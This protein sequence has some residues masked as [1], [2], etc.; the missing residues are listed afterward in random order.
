MSKHPETAFELAE[1]TV[2][3]IH[4]TLRTG[5]RISG[6]SRTAIYNAIGKGELD[7]WRKGDRVMLSN[8]QLKERCLNRPKGRIPEPPYLAA[9]RERRIQKEA[10]SRSKRGGQR[11]V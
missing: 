9:A 4:V 3:P 10:A 8:Q 5:V 6:E 1:A 2:E 7:V 11:R